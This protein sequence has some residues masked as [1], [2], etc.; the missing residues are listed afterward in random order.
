MRLRT[1]AAVALATCFIAFA[2]CGGGCAGKGQFNPTTGVYDTN[3]V[4]DAIVV[5]A[6][7]TR[8][9]A[10]NVFEAFG[11]FEK[12]NDE[13][14]RAVN[15]KIHEAAERI[16]RDGKG[17]LDSLTRAKT[18]YQRTRS[19]EDATKLKNALSIVTSALTEAGKHLATG[20]AATKKTP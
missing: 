8:E 18:D 7:N 12:Q 16:R 6:E 15:P 19:A 10:L 1:F 14:L 13:A 5:T 2:G 17:W 11:V 20:M 3:A 4:A 9:T